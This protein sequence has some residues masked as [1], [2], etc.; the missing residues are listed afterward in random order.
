[1][2]DD[3]D[4]Q[5]RRATQGILVALIVQMLF[6]MFLPGFPIPFV[7][8]V[9]AVGAVGLFFLI[10]SILLLLW[11]SRKWYWPAFGLIIHLFIFGPL[12]LPHVI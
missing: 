2:T 10:L 4:L 5:V 6:A 12:F 11:D 9:A 8:Q 3:T 7:V 1:M